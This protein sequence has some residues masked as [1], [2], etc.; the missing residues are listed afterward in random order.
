MEEDHIN[1]LHIKRVNTTKENRCGDVSWMH[2]PPTANSILFSTPSQKHTPNQRK[3]SSI[4]IIGRNPTHGLLLS[5]PHF[6][7]FFTLFYF[8]LGCEWPAACSLGA[9]CPTPFSFLASKEEKELTESKPKSF[10]QIKYGYWDALSVDL[11]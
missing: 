8:F 9:P 3:P 1:Q 11:C 6:L 2:R 7:L 4:L 10:L 5:G